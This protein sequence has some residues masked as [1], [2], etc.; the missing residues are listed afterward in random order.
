LN[1]TKLTVKKG[2]RSNFNDAEIISGS[3]QGEGFFIPRINF[4]Q[5][6]ITFPSV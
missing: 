1:G 5:S 4:E 6:K 3:N 2:L